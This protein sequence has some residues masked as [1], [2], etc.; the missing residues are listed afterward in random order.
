MKSFL[1]AALL[2]IGFGFFACTES[3]VKLDDQLRREAD[4]TFN[5]RSGPMSRKIDSLCD[6][7]NDSLIQLKFDSIVEVRKKNIREL[8]Q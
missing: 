3:D 6:L 1:P 4:S 8:S 2:L 7:K 5:A